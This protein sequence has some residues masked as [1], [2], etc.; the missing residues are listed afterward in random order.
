MGGAATILEEGERPTREM[1][2]AKRAEGESV[3]ATD[4]DVQIG[5]GGF[6]V[7]GEAPVAGRFQDAGRAGTA[8]FGD[9]AD[10]G[11]DPDGDDGRPHAFVPGG[12]TGTSPWGGGGGAGPHGNQDSGSAD[13]VAA[14]VRV[15]AGAGSS[16]TP[17]PGSSKG[18]APSPSTAA[19]S[20]AA[21]ATRGTAGTSPTRRRPPSRSTSRSTSASRGRSTSSHIQPLLDRIVTSYDYGKGKVYKSSDAVALVQRYVDW[22]ASVKSFDED[23]KAWNGKGGSVDQED[24]YSP[25]FPRQIGAGKVSGKDYTNRLKMPSEEA[26]PE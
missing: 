12:K 23:D 24:Q 3:T 25:N 14:G 11:L 21:R 18:R 1:K 10:E 15:V 26:P 7:T 8:R 17:A 16:T 19:T 4:E 6:P 13:K 5:G 2:A 22:A 20:P 9:A